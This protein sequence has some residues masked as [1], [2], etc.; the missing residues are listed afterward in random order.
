M[1]REK[2]WAFELEAGPDDAGSLLIQC[3]R[4]YG[5]NRSGC[6]GSAGWLASCTRTGGLHWEIVDMAE[7]KAV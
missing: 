5:Y 4:V 1:T 6:A 7:G 2:A 3:C